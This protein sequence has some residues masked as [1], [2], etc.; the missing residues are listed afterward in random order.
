MRPAAAHR[1]RIAAVF[2]GWAGLAT[3]SET[4]PAGRGARPCP[5][6]CADV[7]RARTG[8]D[9]EGEFGAVGTMGE[10]LR[11]GK[12][13]DIL[14]L[15]SN[16]IGTLTQEGHVADGTRADIGTVETA[17]AVRSG[18]EPPAVATGVALRTA[19]LAA[20]EIYFPDPQQATAGRQ[21]PSVQEMHGAGA[22]RAPYVHPIEGRPPRQRSSRAPSPLPHLSCI[23]RRSPII[24]QSSAENASAGNH[25]LAP[26]TKSSSTQSRHIP[27]LVG[28]RPGAA[29]TGS[30]GAN[31]QAACGR[32]RSRGAQCA[33]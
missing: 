27:D 10:K 15:T 29:P 7:C 20:D 23:T 32:M 25:D 2:G 16:L 24:T 6:A 30:A 19:L 1:D 33:R 3:S 22:H 28:A 8:Y 12:P 18:D 4:H 14:I 9:I 13:A 31:R 17:I 5:R 21:S 26:I 11:S